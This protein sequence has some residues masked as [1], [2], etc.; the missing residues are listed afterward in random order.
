MQREKE[1]FRRTKNRLSFFFKILSLM[2]WDNS[3]VHSIICIFL[4]VLLLCK[5]LSICIQEMTSLLL[6]ILQ[7][8]KP[9][10]WL[11]P[12]ECLII[13]GR[14]R[15]NLSLFKYLQLSM[16]NIQPCFVK[17]L[18]TLRVS[19]KYFTDHSLM[20]LMSA[21]IGRE[22]TDCW[23]NP[24]LGRIL[25][26]SSTNWQTSKRC[27]ASKTQEQRCWLSQQHIVDWWLIHLR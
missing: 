9:I 20:L 1:V 22:T 21:L 27:S 25:L 24:F 6:R 4:L 23:V 7:L 19:T 13:S 26:Y 15:K 12:T 5:C 14:S 16:K 3:L 17:I 18:S 2:F 8:K 11:F 10:L